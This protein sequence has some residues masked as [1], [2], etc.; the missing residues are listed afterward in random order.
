MVTQQLLKTIQELLKTNTDTAWLTEKLLQEGYQQ[1]DVG[2]ALAASQ[3]PPK[4]MIDKSGRAGMILQ[5]Y[6]PV[7]FPTYVVSSQFAASFLHDA[8][9][10]AAERLQIENMLQ[11]AGFEHDV[12]YMAA[13]N[14]RRSE[15]RSLINEAE[16]IYD[17]FKIPVQ[18]GDISQQ[19]KRFIK[20]FA[21][22]AVIFVSILAITF[23]LLNKY[24]K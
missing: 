11:S 7:G 13:Q 16:V 24:L 2:V 23:Y 6:D 20:F 3:T 17:F 8:P 18:T 21:L 4:P 10:A 5:T 1:R 15:G 19:Q 12:A 14:Y 22:L 9:P